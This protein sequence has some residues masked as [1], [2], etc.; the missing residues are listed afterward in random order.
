MTDPYPEMTVYSFHYPEVEAVVRE[1]VKEF[2]H[3]LYKQN[4]YPGLDDLH[5]PLLNAYERYARTE[6]GVIGWGR[7]PHR[8][9]VN[10]SSEAIFHLLARHKATMPDVPLYQ[11]E[12]EYQGYSEFARTLGLSI[13]SKRWPDGA[14][15]PGVFI[16]SNPSAIN[17]NRLSNHV[18][19]SA[20]ER[21][22]VIL[23]FAY[24]GMTEMPLEF[25][26]DHENVLAVV[27]SLSKPFGLYYHRI[28]FA[29]SAEPIGSLYGNRW[30]KNAFSI[31]VGEAALKNIDMRAIREKYTTAQC[32]AAQVAG[33]SLGCELQP[34]EVWLLA[35]AKDNREAHNTEVMRR[36]RRGD[37][38]RICLTPYYQ[39]Y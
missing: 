7:F 12:G 25:S 8:Y 33:E 28:G 17:G 29:W 9:Y 2:P 31:K 5:E 24:L 11:L 6:G 39:S 14:Q 27:A 30:F 1:V 38:Y 32:V 19:M 22:K 13:Q 18:L 10:G 3:E 21:H 36:F 34:A 37:D 26:L 16:L 20:L 35:N 23:D 4:W 15:D